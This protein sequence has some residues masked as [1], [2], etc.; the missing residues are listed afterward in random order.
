M[1]YTEGNGV[2]EISTAALPT[3]L[4]F[5]LGLY[6]YME[7]VNSKY[8]H[9]DSLSERCSDMRVTPM[10]R[11]FFQFGALCGLIVLLTACGG[12]SDAQ[13]HAT[14]TR[15]P[16]AHS[17]ATTAEASPSPGILLGPQEC[18][19]LVKDPSSWNQLIPIQA[20]VTQVQGVTCGY[21]KGIPTLQA[22]VTVLHN[23]TS[24]TLDVYVYDHLTDAS[25]LQIFKLQNLVLGAAK[26]S[27]YNSVE[28][29]EVLPTHSQLP[30]EN[31]ATCS[32]DLCREFKWSDG[33]G[34]LVQVIFP[35]LFPD[36]TR[37][38]AED[39]QVQVNQGQQPWKLSATQT[40]QAFGAQLLH[41]DA[42]AT[43]TT[44]SGGGSHDTQAVVSLQNTSPGS[45]ALTIDLARLEGNANGGIWI[46]TGVTSNGLSITQ[47]QSGSIIHST[48]TITGTGSAFEGVIGK[49]SVLDAL[50][51]TLSQA[52]VHGAT[53]NGNTTFTTSLT[54]KAPF[55][56]GAEEGLVLLTATSNATGEVASAAL[57][58]VLIQS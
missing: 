32:H 44:V 45:S 36:L 28:T 52:T 16:A 41:W 24:K 19:A 18:P 22:L 34:T 35:G 49:L 6:S 13:A 26:I 27:G 14:A 40:A 5:P 46:V 57:V 20:G 43:A 30:N 4:L 3:Y 10:K 54:L 23:D 39:D 1:P 9:N 31:V 7:I 33:A 25:P 11:L 55:T 47:P 37:Y 29:A 42:N 8:I 56:N 21:L 38:Q 58:K 12:G 2:E 17:S 50:G 53:G 15:V 48:T 51:N